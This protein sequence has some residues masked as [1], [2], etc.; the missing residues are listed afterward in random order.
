ME[1]PLATYPVLYALPICYQSEHMVYCGLLVPLEGPMT[2]T[3]LAANIAAFS[4]L[5]GYRLAAMPRFRSV[6]PRF[7]INLS[8]ITLANFAF[9]LICGNL[10]MHAVGASIPV[11]MLRVA[12]VLFSSDLGIACLG[13]LY[14]QKRLSR[15]YRLLTLFTIFVTAMLGLASG[16]TQ[17]ALQPVLVFALTRLVVTGRPPLALVGAVIVAV[18]ILQP[19]KSEYRRMAWFG[20]KTD[21]TIKQ[22]IELYATIATNFWLSGRS[23][24]ISVSETV[25]TSANDRMSYLLSTQQYVDLTP[26]EIPYKHGESIAYLFYGWIPRAVWPNKPIAQIADRDYPVEYGIQHPNTVSTTRLGLGQVAEGYVNFGLFGL[27]PLFLLLGMLT[28]FP[29]AIFN[30][31]GGDAASLGLQC[32]TCMKL[33]FVESSIGNVYGGLVTELLTQTILLILVKKVTAS[34]I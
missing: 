6:L 16:M 23:N 2:K 22:K 13:V 31:H 24:N 27:P 3:L 11:S 9:V 5:A 33:M 18:F 25:K 26:R 10:A 21:S 29:K 19:L 17:G 7:H 30:T 20:D 14:F 1:I 28:Y 32:A 15:T 34:L 4:L 12:E 8:P